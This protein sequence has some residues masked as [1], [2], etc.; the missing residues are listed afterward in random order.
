MGL[1]VRDG[2]QW[3][4]VATLSVR[5]AGAWKTITTLSVRDAAAWKTVS[6]GAGAGNLT[7]PIIQSLSAT[8]NSVTVTWS[9]ES[10]AEDEFDLG[11]CTGGG[12]NPTTNIIH[13]EPSTTE[14]STGTLYSH[15]D[16][17]RPEDTIHRYQV[18]AVDTAG[19]TNGDWSA[20]G[21][22]LTRL[23]PPTNADVQ[24]EGA[25]GFTATWTDNSAAATDHRVRWRVSGSGDP[26]SEATTGSGDSTSH[27]ETGLAADTYEVQ[28]RAEKTGNDS[29]WVAAGTVEVG[30]VPSQLSL[31]WNGT[32]CGFDLDW[33]PD[34][35]NTQDIWHCSGTGCTPQNGTK[36]ATV[37]AGVSTHQDTAPAAES[38]DHSYQIVSAAGES[39]IA[40]GAA[41][42]CV[43]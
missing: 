19:P 2:G 24:P 12:C 36:I 16:T 37:A 26:W 38:G 29:V 32:A 5:D 21:E 17:A 13:T 23:N 20:V 14:A 31:T 15:D 34:P 7:P 30:A 4:E 33:T 9:D 40:E 28:V 18:R 6:L 10:T 1:W 41:G 25:D 43:E 27:T 39:N 3:K 42:M 8:H 22:V 35:D 11:R